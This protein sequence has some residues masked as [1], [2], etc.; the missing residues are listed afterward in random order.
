MLPPYRMP[1][2]IA[3]AE[4]FDLLVL[5]SG[6]EANRSWTAERRG[7]NIKYVPGWVIPITSK[8]SGSVFDRQ[9]MHVPPLILVELL[10]FKPQYIISSE[11]GLRTAFA[12]AAAALLDS[13]LGVWWGGTPHT[14]SRIS[15]LRNLIRR[16]IIPVVPQWLTYGSL[17]AEYLRTRGVENDR[18][19]QLQ[20]AVDERHYGRVPVA[21]DAEPSTKFLCV[22]QLIGRKGVDLLIRAF[23][24]ICPERK[25]SLAI[26]GSGPERRELEE[27]ADSLG[28]GDRISFLGEVAYGE[29]PQLYSSV[30]CLV[31]PTL[32]DVWGL[33]INEALLSGTPVIASKFAG[34]ATDLL[35]V[36]NVFDPTHEEDF[37]NALR[38]AGDR[39]IA[40]ADQC[41]T[42]VWPI[43][44]VA[45]TIIETID[46]ALQP[47]PRLP[48]GP[49]V[50]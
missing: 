18:I 41:R 6:S 13:K 35:P 20:N 15:P 4:R 10:R 50:F 9:Y 40:T 22:S 45:D 46:Q 38:R 33:V 29:M 23:S 7:L 2:C 43:G 28:I 16:I 32:Q 21:A 17:A 44:R 26:A 24:R 49:V 14:E 31:F 37:V 5:C 3:L 12:I 1:I 47:S 19:I 39:G 30:D 8:R 48:A 34:A 25:C 11:I 36:E 42:R 27:L